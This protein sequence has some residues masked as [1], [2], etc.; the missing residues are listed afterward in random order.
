ML[1]NMTSDNDQH[2]WL[3]LRSETG[4][5][6]KL[7]QVRYDWMRNPRNGAEER[8]VILEGRDSANV[9][10]LTPDNQVLLIRQYRFGIG[11]DTL[12]LPGGLMEAGEELQAGVTR[13]LAEETGHTSDVWE[14]LGKVP[15][16]P[17]FMD[18]YIHHWVARNVVCSTSPDLDDGEAVE[19]VFLPLEKVLDML[20]SGAFEHPHT[21][22]A[23]LRFFVGNGFLISGRNG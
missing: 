23:L 7:F 9:V 19:L 17:V 12:E 18:S 22:T 21:V 15:S 6:I 8:M 10:A 11:A 3:R 1:E 16:N 20:L 5:H 13:E 4:P 2:N 14:Y